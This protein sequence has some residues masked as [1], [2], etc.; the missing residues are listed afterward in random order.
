M[1]TQKVEEYIV[2]WLID[3][4]VQNKINGY[5]IGISGGIDSAV[6]STLCGKTGL[7]TLCLD[8]PIRQNLSQLFI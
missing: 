6:T 5:V 3:Y 8:I 2:Q 4:K 1:D 7:Q